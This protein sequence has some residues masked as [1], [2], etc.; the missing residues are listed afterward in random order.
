MLVG[1]LYRINPEY[2][3]RTGKVPTKAWR[4]RGQALA[5][6]AGVSFE[7]VTGI[8][9]ALNKTEKTKLML[10][11]LRSK[12]SKEPYKSLL[13][14]T[15]SSVLHEQGKRRDGEHPINDWTKPGGD[16]LG[17]LLMSIRAELKNNV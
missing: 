16:L 2:I 17:Q 11:C 10:R 15:G 6:L 5:E 9:G 12:Y 4:E 14:S 1:G 3:E 13:L 8:K 7:E